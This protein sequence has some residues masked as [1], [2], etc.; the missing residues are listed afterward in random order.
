MNVALVNSPATILTTLLTEYRFL[1][2]E[3]KLGKGPARMVNQ[4]G[5]DIGHVTEADIDAILESS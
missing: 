3:F 5:G 2:L 4:N 1:D